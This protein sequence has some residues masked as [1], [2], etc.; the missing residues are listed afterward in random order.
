MGWDAQ[1]YWFLAVNG[2]PADLPLTD[3]GAVAENQ[4]AFMPI[5]AY[6]AAAIAPLV[7]GWWGVAA[8]LISLAAGYGATYVLYRMLRG[9]IGGS[10]AIWASAFFA[11]GPLAALF[12]VGYAEALFLLWLFLALWAVTA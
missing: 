10:A 9:R 12:Q 5:Y 8:V 3:A 1:W 6:L 11:A 7:G 2:Y 4:W